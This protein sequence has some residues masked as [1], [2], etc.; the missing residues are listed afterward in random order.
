M[1]EEGGKADVPGQPIAE[2]GVHVET[3]NIIDEQSKM[4]DGQPPQDCE[5]D[6]ETDITK[7]DISERTDVLNGKEPSQ[8]AVASDG[9]VEVSL[10]AVFLC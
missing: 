9:N 2:E 6:G 4:E 7:Q 10:R 8:E 3:E 1:S 5:G